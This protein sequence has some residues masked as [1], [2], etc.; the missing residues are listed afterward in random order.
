MG[1][2]NGH[3]LFELVSNGYQGKYLKGVDYSPASVKL[4]KQIAKSKGDNFEE[5][6]FDVVD[7]LDKQQ[8]SNLGQWDV[9]MDKGTFGGYSTRPS[10]SIMSLRRYMSLRRL[11]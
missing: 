2:G 8:I 6:T 11:K 5:V 3:L 1:T 9:V 4:S 7:V 10:I